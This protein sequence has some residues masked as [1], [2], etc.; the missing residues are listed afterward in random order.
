MPSG[1]CRSL[2]RRSAAAS[3]AY[4]APTT[5]VEFASYCADEGVQRHY[6]ASYSPQQNS[7]IERRN[8]TVVGMA[9]ALLKQR[10]M[11]AVFWGEAVVT[12]V[13]IL[14]RSPTKA[15]NGM[16]P[17]EAW[18]GR[19]PAVSHL[20]VFGCLAFTKELGHIGKLDN[21]STPGVFIGYA[22]G[23][24][25]YRILDPG[26]LRVRTTRDVVFDEGRGW[27]WDKAVDDG[28][29][30]TYDDFTIEYVYFEGAGGVGD[31]S[32]S[33]PTLAPKSPLTPTPH[34]PVLATTSSSPPRNPPTTPAPAS[35]PSPRTP[36]PTVPSP[37]TSSPTPGRVEH[38]PVELVTPLSHDEEH[39][40]AC[41]DGESLR[42][43]KVEGL[44]ID[45]SV[46]GPAS[47][48][49]AGKLH[50]ACDN[51]EPRSFAE[52][53]K[54][55]AWCA[56]MQ[57]EMDAVETNCTWEL[58]ELP[59]GHRAITLK[60]VFKLKRDE[61]GAIVKHKARL[62]AHGFLQQEGIDFDDAFAHVAR[63]ESMQLLLALSAKEGWHV[64]H[65][66]V[67][68]AF[69]NGGLK[70]EVYVQ[71]PLG[72]AIPGKEGKVLRLRKALYGL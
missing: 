7:V 41:Y 36:A 50:L 18:H 51:G 23:S 13:Y 29:T 27:A 55:A 16:T 33:R 25:A 59:H 42:Y 34:S 48:I 40:D 66:D 10:G 54:H 8:Q 44:L 17:Y 37:G 4:C 32:S 31:P 65:M 63:M 5:A 62:V 3:C 61:V 11:S 52:A 71:Q 21:R 12:A 70:E 49:L 39:V 53:E 14:N 15:L 69:L 64:H 28:T 38:D 58:A 19:K 2:W 47:R 35:S 9:R 26:T 56:A 57:S 43:R 22:E 72:F 30:L 68:S 60:W 6:S 24:K 67:K 45:P 1:V 46:P 20:R